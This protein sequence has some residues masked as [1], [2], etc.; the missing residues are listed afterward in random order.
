M[1]AR[2]P[3]RAPAFTFCVL[4]VRVPV[5]VLLAC[6]HLLGGGVART[7]ARR[8]LA[9]GFTS[10][11]LSLVVCSHAAATCCGSSSPCYQP[12]ACPRPAWQ[13]FGQTRQRLL[14][15]H[16]PLVMAAL[17]RPAPPASSLG[18]HVLT[19]A[20]LVDGLAGYTGV[21][22]GLLVQSVQAISSTSS[23]KSTPPSTK[24]RATSAGDVPGSR[25]RSRVRCTV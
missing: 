6:Q 11:S 25:V 23:Q 12:S 1:R 4:C 3:E 20:A 15:P 24:T 17:A 8:R 21:G 7:R 2:C 5:S 19:A 10:T 18:A 14:P 16:N 22:R 13:L 9:C